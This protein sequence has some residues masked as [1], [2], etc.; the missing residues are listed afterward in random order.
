M[1][2]EIVQL[3]RQLA[4]QQSGSPTTLQ[5]PSISIPSVKTESPN[6]Y[7]SPSTHEQYMGSQEAVASLLDLRSGHDGAAYLRN[8]NGQAAMFRRI[9]DVALTLDRVRDLF[10]LY[11]NTF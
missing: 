10:N 8:T 5:T 9:D 1:E 6:V 4:S 3:R 2:R 7:Q 11:V